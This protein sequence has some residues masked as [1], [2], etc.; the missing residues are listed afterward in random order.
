MRGKQSFGLCKLSFPPNQRRRLDRQGRVFEC[1][2]WRKHPT[3]RGNREPGQRGDGSDKAIAFGRYRLDEFRLRWIIS[4]GLA[5]FSDSGVQPV[6]EV[7]HDIASPYG[8]DDL[9]AEHELAS[10]LDEQDEHLHRDSFE[11]ERLFVPSELKVGRIELKSA[12]SEETL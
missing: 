1:L 9:L 8:F 11:M 7:Q 3:R 2:E 5:E 10:P 4:Q 6:V 12:K